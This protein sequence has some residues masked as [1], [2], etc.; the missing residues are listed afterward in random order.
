M[1][2]ALLNQDYY[3]TYTETEELVYKSL[4]RVQSSL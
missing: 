2:E 4:K 3:N 1:Q